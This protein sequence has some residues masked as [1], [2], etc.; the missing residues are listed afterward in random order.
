MIVKKI[1]DKINVLKTE[2]HIHAFYKNYNKKP[3]NGK[4]ILIYAG[5]GKMYIS[6]FEILLY[7]LFQ[8]DG[9]VVDFLI[10]DENILIHELITQDVDDRQGASLYL[11][12]SIKNSKKLLNV[13][14]V[15]FQFINA[16]RNEVSDEVENVASELQKILCYNKDGIDFGVIVQGAMYRYYKSLD[17]SKMSLNVAK[18]FLHTALTNYYEIEE[19][20]KQN[21][22][23]YVL[24]SHGIYVTWEPIV[25]FCKLYNQNF[26]SYDRA[27]TKNT[28]NIN[29]NQISPD[30]SF[31]SAWIR[32]KNRMLNPK[33]KDLVYSY[34]KD[35]ELQN[36]DVYAYNFSDRT[37]DIKKLKYDLGIPENSRVITFFTNLIWDAA[38][39]SR[40]I[41][42]RSAFECITQTIEHYRNNKDIHIVLRSHP[43][44]KIVGTKE[45]YGT[46]LR[47]YFNNTLPD[48]VTIIEPEMAVNSFSVID[49]SD[50][51]VVNTS[52]V[53]LE[54]AL[55]GKPI[56]LISETHYRNKG[57]T[58]DVN[59]KENYFS[60]LSNLI[61]K[62]DL[63]ENQKI[64]AEKY[65]YMMMFKYQ[66]QVP[67]L[68]DT[69][70][71][72][73]K[74]TYDNIDHISKNN[75][76]VKIMNRIINK[77]QNDFVFWDD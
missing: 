48:N 64:L 25:E 26:I 38:N 16:N 70:G 56:I 1:K 77:N 55:L 29:F 15:D 30:W 68:Y 33:E 51:G 35:R 50:I 27:K 22:Y 71:R 9:Y 8:K 42:F 37:S 61:L 36:T 69:N 63:K 65:F 14:Q 72:F 45:K 5:I 2:R 17:I 66:H 10:Y 54:F 53:G 28:I 13:G 52:T 23:E 44:E 4:R 76:M 32:Y 31:D 21:N 19:R 62:T 67:L 60:T 3:P 47:E 41:A 12:K 57:F 58:Y 40:D 46:L 24:F 43:A 34:L 59:S 39:V 20:T 74:Y 11:N 18:R 73:K 49:I 7:H 6:Y 75:E